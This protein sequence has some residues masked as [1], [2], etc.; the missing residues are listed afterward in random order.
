MA[1]VKKTKQKTRGRKNRRITKN[2]RYPKRSKLPT[3]ASFLKRCHTSVKAQ[4]ANS[5]DIPTFS[6]NIPNLSFKEKET[7][8]DQALLLFRDCYVHLPLKEAMHAVAPIQQLTLLKSRLDHIQDDL[9]F[10]NQMTEI[11]NSVRDLHTNYLLPS[12]FRELTAFLPFQVEAYWEKKARKYLVSHV[13][14][15]FRHATFKPGVEITHW[16]GVPIERAVQRIA[17]LHAGSNMDARHARGVTGLTIRPLIRSLPPDEEWIIIRY[18]TADGKK[19]LEYKQDWLIFPPQG[20]QGGMDADATSLSATIVGLDLEADAIRRTTKV[21]FAPPEVNRTLAL[22]KTDFPDTKAPDTKFPDTKEP[23]TKFPNLAG[24]G[25]K[26][27]LTT[28]KGKYL[29]RGGILSGSTESFMPGVFNARAVSTKFGTFGYIRIR[30]FNVN[31][32]NTFVAEFVRLATLLP[33]NG[34]IIDV[35]DNGGGLIHAGERLLQTLTPN[36]I[37]PERLQFV[38]TPLTLELTKL[39]AKSK[40]I[41]DFDLGPWV[42]SIKQ[43]VETGATYSRGFPITSP[44]SANAIGQKYHGPVVLI[45]NARCY[46]TTDIFAAGFQDHEIGPILGTDNNTGA[47]GA[48]VW[49]HELLQYLFSKP[50]P[51]YK[52]LPDSPF[53]KLPKNAGMRVAIRRNLRVRAQAGTPLEDLGV[54]PD[55]IHNMTRNDLLKKNVDLIEEAG[56]MLSKQKHRIYTLDAQIKSELSGDYTGTA[57]TKNLNRLDVYVNDRPLHSL[58]IKNGVHTFTLPKLSASSIVELKGYKRGELVASRRVGL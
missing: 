7:L 6:S 25:L 52:P 17:D 33:Q 42:E 35:R 39:H 8:I 57:T 23:D 15:G 51:P 19:E 45:T 55:K 38:N 24:D 27:V 40:H 3:S 41:Q 20:E 10:H 58:S 18:R 32:A 49:T 1:K 28:K 9:Q 53:S 4:L 54:K 5:I 13:V 47:G 11:F 26:K 31:S 48:N 50:K 43:A 56:Q 12:P 34:L 30:T 22:P 29:K 2:K 44:E 46:S 16:N 37:E 14:D 21:L 36:T